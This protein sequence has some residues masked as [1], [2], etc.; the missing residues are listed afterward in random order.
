ML[1][2]IYSLQAVYIILHEGTQSFSGMSITS[3]YPFL[4][5]LTSILILILTHTENNRVYHV[6]TS[7]IEHPLCTL[8]LHVYLVYVYVPMYTACVYSHPMCI[9]IYV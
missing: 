6:C 2:C 7:L 4:F 5:I 1:L 3:C 8:V 9:V